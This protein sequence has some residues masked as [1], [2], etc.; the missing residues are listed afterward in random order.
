MST[1][2][3]LAARQLAAYN[4]GDLDAFVGCYH[5]D[6]VVLEGQE[7][8]V[9]GRAAMAERYADLFDTGGFGATSPGRLSEGRHC[10]DLEAW[11]RIDPDTGV[12]T[13]GRLLVRYSE[14]DGL[15][16]EVQ[17]LLEPDLSPAQDTAE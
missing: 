2:T 1:I 17:F 8:T 14:R 5:P 4:R 16:G 7:V 13:D 10:V 11:W 3:D 9:R 6:V 15:I 12:R